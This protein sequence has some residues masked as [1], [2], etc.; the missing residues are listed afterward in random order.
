MYSWAL[1][2]VSFLTFHG[3]LGHLEVE[4]LHGCLFKSY[5]GGGQFQHYNE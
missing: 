1:Y 2:T 3:N 4:E 5:E